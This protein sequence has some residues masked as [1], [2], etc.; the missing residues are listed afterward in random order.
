MRSG[1]VDVFLVLAAAAAGACSNDSLVSTDSPTPVVV[2]GTSSSPCAPPASACVLAAADVSAAT[3]I[4]LSVATPRDGSGSSVTAASQGTCEYAAG[5]DGGGSDGGDGSADDSGPSVTA[6][7]SCG[8]SEETSTAYVDGY[9]DQVA[10]G[11][12][13]PIAGLGDY[14]VWIADGAAGSVAAL[15]GN[16]YVTVAYDDATGG[17]APDVAQARAA[18]VAKAYLASLF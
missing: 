12:A 9:R 7:F 10:N 1:G 18:A 17:T 2:P 16:A 6:A 14:A 15:Q 8:L 4:D 11:G 3:G 13:T 5:S